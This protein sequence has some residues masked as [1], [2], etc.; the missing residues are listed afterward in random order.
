MFRRMICGFL[1]AGGLLSLA[2]PARAA[3]SAGSIRVTLQNGETVVPDGA[4]TLYQVGTPTDGGYRLTDD[5]G[6][7]I[8][9]DQDALSP[10]LARWLWEEAGSGGDELLLDADGSAAF[11]DLPEGLYLLVQTQAST[12]YHLMAPMTVQIPCE[13]QWNVQAYPM[14][15]EIIWELPPTA[16]PFPLAAWTACL[17]FSG[18]GLVLLTF[19]K[20]RRT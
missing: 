5:F 9:K 20:R 19:R 11:L 15:E 16:D 18:A 6:G 3:Q 13:Y 7:G 4:V 14:M 10:I 2:A 8:I 1:I 17:V 12:G